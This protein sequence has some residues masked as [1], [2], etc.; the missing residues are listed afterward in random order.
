MKVGDKA[1]HIIPI[2]SQSLS[3]LSHQYHQRTTKSH[4]NGLDGLRRLLLGQNH[5]VLHDGYGKRN[6]LFAHKRGL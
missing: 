1:N 3:A 2:A 5:M 4:R 6:P